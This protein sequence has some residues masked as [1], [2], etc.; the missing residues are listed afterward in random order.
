MVTAVS[1]ILF[2]LY[3]AL[4]GWLVEKPLLIFFHFQKSWRSKLIGAFL[5]FILISFG[6]GLITIN[7]YFSDIIIAVILVATAL[8]CALFYYWAKRNEFLPH[9]KIVEA[10]KFEKISLKQ[11][12]L[13]AV[14]IAL[15]VYGFYLLTLSS[16][17]LS[18]QTPWQVIN[19]QFIYIFILAVFVL[20]LLIYFR[21]PI[22]YALILLIVIT[23]LQHSYLPLTNNLF[24]GADGWRHISTEQRLFEGLKIDEPVI[25][26][27]TL[28]TKLTSYIGRF[29]YS[30][31]WG[32]SVMLSK[33][34]SVNLID[35]NRWLMPVMWGILF[36]ILL[37]EIARSFGRGNRRS[38]LFVWLSLLPFAFQAA[39][40]FTLPVNF[41]FLIWLASLLLIFRRSE[42]PDRGQL[43]II[44][45]FG[46]IITFGYTLFA[47]LF[48]VSFI[49]FEVIKWRLEFT[50]TEVAMM[51]LGFAL[52]LLAVEWKFGYAFYLGNSAIWDG[53]KQAIGSL[54]SYYLAS[55]PR[56]H[57]IL[58]GNIILNQAPT[59][60][61]VSNF[62]TSSLKWLLPVMIVFWL[63]F[64]YGIYVV[65]IRGFQ[66]LPDLPGNDRVNIY[67]NHYSWLLIA[68]FGL[69][70]SYILGRYFFSGEHLLIRRLDVVLAFFMMLVAFTAFYKLNLENRYPLIATFIMVV[71]SIFIGVSYSLGP[72]TKNVSGEEYRAVQYVASEEAS[73]D[74]HCVIAET[75]PLLALESVT[76][77]GVLGGGFPISHNFEQPEL[78]RLQMNLN[79]IS[80]IDVR[81]ALTLTQAKRCWLF[82][83]TG[84]PISYFI[85]SGNSTSTQFGSITI[86]KYSN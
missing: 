50:W 70:L 65:I 41:G 25:S 17:N 59:Y 67:R 86:W 27:A 37:F 53:L 20:G 57:D 31:L 1:L 22:S 48:W 84:G 12:G 62:F 71:V 33:I 47:L 18:V 52:F 23:F 38:L 61:F 46:I 5:G 24:Y 69:L 75:Y 11:L 79:D 16:V 2:G 6:A 42:N 14:F 55:G 85:K 39:G 60:A 8:V 56:P 40:S 73:E 64:F 19:H 77:G 4:L 83:K 63:I 26:D 30:Q 34:L 45:L 10:P 72:D 15:V 7:Y 3:L 58:S 49:I 80:V 43:S 76:K 54:S 74:K 35:L 9:E 32:A 51:I 21:L 28:T 29:A 81:A 66:S 36:P 44:I 82:A 78:S 13:V 68:C